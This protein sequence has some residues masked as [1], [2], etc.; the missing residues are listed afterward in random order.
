MSGLARQLVE[1]AARL[2]P[3]RARTRYR[4]EWLA[5]LDGAA[6]AGVS[7]ASV[8]TG[9]FALSATIDRLDPVH[10]GL[11]LGALFRHRL[12]E[13]A[14]LLLAGLVLLA[15]W[16]VYG[17]Y[18][19][20]PVSGAALAYLGTVVL[21]A[22]LALATAGL[23]SLAGAVHIAAKSGR[24]VVALV[25]LLAPLV[26]G[27]LLLLALPFLML[28]AAGGVLLVALGA[29]AAAGSSRPPLPRGRR[30]LLAAGFGVAAIATCVVGILHVAVWN[31]LARVP[32]LTLGEIYASL[33]AAG[34][35]V[36]IVP[37]S[38]VWAVLT[39]FGA[40][41]LLVVAAL[42]RTV[43]VTSTRRLVVLGLLL[44][45]ITTLLGF[46][47][48]FGMGMSL[49]DTFMTSGGDAAPTGP[50]L[51]LVGQLAFAASMLV[52]FVRPAI[53]REEPVA[54]PS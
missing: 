40:V 38:I 5:D 10:T 28:G 6:E 18:Q 45:A 51:A 14:G 26:V 21:V 31:P 35:S 41:A 8:V 7:R 4:E 11:A 20:V 39:L 46:P 52:G 53:I 17:G 13:A 3:P 9:A 22:A 34:E 36:A 47:P 25:L 23:L 49:A 12:R 24:L 2:L 29:I 37:W 54:V 30:M 16:Y 32:G 27:G 15:G 19:S 50:L 33:A 1:L 43:G 42:R 48:S 44:V